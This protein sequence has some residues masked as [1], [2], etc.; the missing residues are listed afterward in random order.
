MK[1]IGGR[2]KKEFFSKQVKKTLPYQLLVISLIILAIL[3]LIWVVLFILGKVSYL[4][5]DEGL[6]GELGALK[7]WHIEN[8][9]EG[10]VSWWEF[11]GNA[12][13]S[14]GNNNGILNNNASIIDDVEKGLV[15]NLDGV[16]GYVGVADDTSLKPNNEI[17]VSAWVN[18]KSYF[19]QSGYK[20]AI[21]DKW[22]FDGG[23]YPGYSLSMDDGSENNLWWF[24]KTNN[25][26]LCDLSVPN[27]YAPLNEWHLLTG[28]YNGTDIILYVNGVRRGKENCTGSLLHSD[29]ILRIGNSWGDPTEFNGTIDD[30]MIFNRSF[31]ELEVMEFYE[32]FTGVM[33]AQTSLIANITLYNDDSGIDILDLDDYFTCLGS[34]N[35][36]S[37]E[38]PNNDYALLKINSTTNLITLI[39]GSTW[40]GVQKFD[41]TASCDGDV[42]NVL[43]NGKNM[44]FYIIAID[45]DRVLI[46]NAPEFLEDDCSDLEWGENTNYF[47]DMDDCF[48]DDDGDDLE[49]RY[50]NSSGY[51]DNLT[52]EIDDD[53]LTLIPDTDW[54]GSGYFYIYADDSTDETS[55][56]VYFT[57]VE[58][59]TS[60]SS[61]TTSSTTSDILEIKSSSPSSLTVNIFT[62]K[63]KKFSITAQNYDNIRWY[64]DG[65]MVLEGSLSYNFKKIDEGEY[66]IKVEVVNGT[67]TDS[68]TWNLVVQEEEIEDDLFESGEVIFY[69]IVG[70]IF[71]IIFLILWLFIVEKNSR[72]K[73]INYIGFGI[74][75]SS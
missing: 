52:I 26:G 70:I 35:F 75:G 1:K 33:L 66:I 11:E 39:K 19:E 50:G 17:T 23:N 67:L 22:E 64:L 58:N 28:V 57:V 29:E 9:P 53:E 71:I 61:S 74:S 54:F 32:N 7:F 31:N 47:I 6:K 37:I 55:G 69:L 36:S 21:V 15:L 51:N 16:E 27:G 4:P 43:T 45:G 40:Y 42:L 5:K 62:N 2:K 14:I 8:L 18:A 30:V 73:K 44:S 12:D 60:T 38:D 10:L 3:I 65:D 48:E 68:K 41:L 56:R 20:S 46:N 49:F 24:V 34:I 25:T 63:T 72:K 59:T 13:D